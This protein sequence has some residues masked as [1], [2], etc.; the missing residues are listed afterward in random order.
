MSGNR[1]VAAAFRGALIGLESRNYSAVNNTVTTISTS[2]LTELGDLS[3][4]HTVIPFAIGDR[5]SNKSNYVNEFPASPSLNSQGSVTETITFLGVDEGTS[6]VGGS[7]DYSCVFRH[8]I[9]SAG[10]SERGVYDTYMHRLGGNIKTVSYS[11][12][13]PR[14]LVYQMVSDT[15]YSR[16]LAAAR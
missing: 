2:T 9:T 13:Y 15:A 3:S 12:L 16:R 6:V 4:G 10:S 14:P 11:A 5:V 7:F 8:E 1:G